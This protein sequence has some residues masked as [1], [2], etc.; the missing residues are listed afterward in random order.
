M[1][2]SPARVGDSA[3]LKWIPYKLSRMQFS[4]DSDTYGHRFS[5]YS[6]QW[7]VPVITVVRALATVWLVCF[8][9]YFAACMWL[10][11][12]EALVLQRRLTASWLAP[13]YTGHL[14]IDAMFVVAGVCLGRKLLT[15]ARSVLVC[16]LPVWGFTVIL[17]RSVVGSFDF[18]SGNHCLHSGIVR[19]GC[20][21]LTSLYPLQHTPPDPCG[22]RK[23][24]S[25]HAL[26]HSGFKS[27]HWSKHQYLSATSA[28]RGCGRSQ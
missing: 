4:S 23:L 10:T 1:V 24:P 11:E 9:S 2:P 8:L 7:N 19:F 21:C 25:R 6:V 22:H 12:T 16:S 15:Q 14:A 13:L 3:I 26:R 20:T 17:C 5:G 18:R 28:A 27:S